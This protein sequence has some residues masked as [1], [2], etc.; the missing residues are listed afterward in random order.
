M[1]LRQVGDAVG[2]VGDVFG[3]LFVEFAPG[4]RGEPTADPGRRVLIPLD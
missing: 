4:A 3:G 2:Y 1:Q